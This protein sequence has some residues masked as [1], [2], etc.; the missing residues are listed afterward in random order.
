[1][2]TSGNREGVQDLFVNLDLVEGRNIGASILHGF[3]QSRREGVKA[4]PFLAQGGWSGM[5]PY[6][7]LAVQ[8]CT[9]YLTSQWKRANSVCCWDLEV[10]SNLYPSFPCLSPE[11]IETPRQMEFKTTHLQLVKLFGEGDFGGPIGF[12]ISPSSWTELNPWFNSPGTPAPGA[13]W[14][15]SAYGSNISR[16][17]KC[18][19]SPR[20]TSGGV[21][22]PTGGNRGGWGQKPGS[23]SLGNSPSPHGSGSTGVH[24]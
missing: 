4:I 2:W 24:L 19:P 1:M 8:P 3:L 21:T 6:Q 5:R 10:S 23:S 20:F 17:E 22:A 14:T 9:N 16:R 7:V 15:H 18:T 13:G 11:T 12:L